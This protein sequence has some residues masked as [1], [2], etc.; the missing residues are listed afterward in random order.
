[1]FLSCANYRNNIKVISC[2]SVLF[3]NSELLQLCS[4]CTLYTSLVLEAYGDINIK[5][6]LVE[7]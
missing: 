6:D 1:M 3:N 4:A 2:T 5:A 7:I